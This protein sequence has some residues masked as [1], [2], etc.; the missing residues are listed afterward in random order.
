MSDDIFLKAENLYLA[1]GSHRD[2]SFFLAC[3]DINVEIE[4]HEFVAVVGPS[5]C[6]KTTFLEAVA[7]LVPVAA[8]SITL[9]GEPI[10][11]PGSDRSIVFQR[12]SLL[13]W[14]NV[15][16]N[17]AFG[18]EMR[19]RLTR[20]AKEEVSNLIEMVGLS[21]AVDRYP[22]ALSGGMMQRAN[23][24]R[25]LA[26][27]PSLLLLDE[28]FSALDA[29]TREVLQDEL[30]RIWQ[31]DVIGGMKTA[32]FITHD[33]P[34][35]VLLADRILVLSAHPGTVVRSIAVNAPRPRHKEWKKTPEFLAYCDEIVGLLQRPSMTSA[36]A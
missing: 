21:N 23:L 4:E 13:P 22:R 32:I 8:G 10:R 3:S 27:N 1:H 5:G 33:V 30:L 28:P 20:Q 9:R 31:D 34:E 11:G 25:A 19:G 36:G 12:P 26:T 7:G 14:R 2:R 16:D 18:L 24:A 35:A 29:Q 17:V 6:G 15:R